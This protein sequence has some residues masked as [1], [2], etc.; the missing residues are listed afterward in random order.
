MKT[1]I[2][3]YLPGHAGNFVAR[4]FSLGRETMPLMQQHMLQHH[5]ESVTDIPNDFD[6][7]ENYRFST[8]TAAFNNWQQFHRSYA[9]YKEY[10]C[11]N[12]LNI[13]C[14]QKYSRIVFP[15]HPHEFIADF[16]NQS[17]SEFYYVDLDLEQWGDWVNEQQ[18]KLHF[19]YRHNEHQQFEDLKAKHR[20]CPISLTRLLESH[21]SFLKEYYRICK[22][23]DIDPLPEQALLLRQDWMSVRVKPENIY[24]ISQ[25]PNDDFTHDIFVDL[26]KSHAGPSEAYYI[27]SSPPRTL[28]TFLKHTPF[29]TPTIIIGIKDLLEAYDLEQFNWWQNPTLTIVSLIRDMAKQHAD[30][31]FILFVS[32]EQLELSLDEPNLHIIPWGGDWVNQRAGYS[33]LMPVLDKNFN[34]NKTF[35]NLNRHARDHR[36]V[37]LSYL[38][39]S[40]VADSGMI[41]YLGNVNE[42][43]STLLLDRIYWEFDNSEIKEKILTGFDLM[44][45]AL[46]APGDTFDIYHVYGNGQ[47]DNIGNF[48]NQ[49][50]RRYRDSFVE[51]VSESS[52]TPSSFMLTEKTAHAFYG[53]NFPI[54][55][56]GA[57]AVAHLREL[58]FDMFDDI[59]DHSYDLISNPIDRIVTAIDANRRLLTDTDHAKQSWNT[60][61]SRFE[62]N[63]EVMRDIYTWYEQ[64][65][66]QKFT[67]TLELFK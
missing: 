29:S 28:R 52:F 5:L 61:R 46:D 50:R 1:V 25:P 43:R 60:C 31:N 7:L 17:Q 18:A 30:K 14:K 23:M 42:N 9:D 3:L 4:L 45:S 13:Y 41:T 66:R 56:S 10:S 57:G 65:T 44:R 20:M 49:L 62:R 54:M 24:T 15:L 21:E 32:V 63:V 40:G 48:E 51:I 26:V 35:I 38:F 37:T 55:L 59:I 47:N 19:Q 53:C 27:W 12:L 11:Y 39:G 36:I 8:V 58:G 6:R 64:R 16:D 34:S 33:R 67:E 2:I 22:I